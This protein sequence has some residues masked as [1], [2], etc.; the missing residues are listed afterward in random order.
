M[1]EYGRP[2]GSGQTPFLRA[3]RGASSGAGAPGRERLLAQDPVLPGRPAAGRPGLS[4]DPDATRKSALVSRPRARGSR[5]RYASVTPRRPAPPQA[6]LWRPR[7]SAPRVQR[8][9]A[10]PPGSSEEGRRALP[11]EIPPEMLG[12]PQRGHPGRQRR[13]SRELRR[14]AD[15]PVSGLRPRRGG[16]P[17]TVL[18]DPGG[19]TEA[20]ER[21]TYLTK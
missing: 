1:G 6:C 18:P 16:R 3:E 17:R 13:V 2:P 15:A 20:W 8:V 11:W 21:L 9:G 5:R 10:R 14:N 7:G 19:Y 12:G 4:P